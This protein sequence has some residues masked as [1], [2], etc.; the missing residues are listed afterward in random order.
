MGNLDQLKSRAN[1]IRKE[2]EDG[3]N[4]SDRVGGLLEDMVSAMQD[5]DNKAD[6]GYYVCSTSGGTSAKAVSVPGFTLSTRGRLL[7]KMTYSNTAALPSLNINQTG[8]KP[9]YYNGEVA[10]ADNTWSD[11][12][13]LDVYYDGT[14][15]QASNVQ[16]GTDE[17]ALL[18][19]IPKFVANTHYYVGQLVQYRGQ[20]YQNKVEYQGQ[21]IAGNWEKSSLYLAARIPQRTVLQTSNTE[22]DEVVFPDAE[23][24]NRNARW[25]DINGTAWLSTSNGYISTDVVPCAPFSKFM[26]FTL[27]YGS[28]WYLDVNMRILA[29][30]VAIAPSDTSF[31]VYTRQNTGQLPLTKVVLDRLDRGTYS[32]ILNYNRDVI[33]GNLLTLA[34]TMVK[35]DGSLG[36]NSGSIASELIDVAVGDVFLIRNGRT[37]SGIPL[38][39]EC[40]Y[41]YDESGSYI[42]TIKSYYGYMYVHSDSNVKK[43][44]FVGVNRLGTSVKRFNQYAAIDFYNDS[45]TVRDTF[46]QLLSD[47][48]VYHNG[49]IV[50]REIFPIEVTLKTF[51]SGVAPA[52]CRFDLKALVQERRLQMINGTLFPYVYVT[53]QLLSIGDPSVETIKI[54]RFQMKVG[55]V[56]KVG[57]ES[58]AVSNDV[59][60][61]I[62]SQQSGSPT[63][64]TLKI[65]SVTLGG[66]DDMTGVFPG[67]QA[68]DLAR[69]C[70]SLVSPYWY[71]MD[72]TSFGDSITYLGTYNYPRML[73]DEMGMNLNNVAVP[74]TDIFQILND[75][76]LSLLSRN[77][78][79]VTITAGSN[80]LAVEYG[81]IDSRDRT[82][83]YGCINYAIDYILEKCPRALIMLCPAYVTKDEG[84]NVVIRH[85]RQAFYDI[86]NHRGGI[87]VCDWYT[88]SGINTNTVSFYCYDGVHPNGRTCAILAGLIKRKMNFPVLNTDNLVNGDGYNMFQNG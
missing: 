81:D 18:G 86:S 12:E 65:I 26:N 21:W 38:S 61:S 5:L 53:M 71:G 9:L 83:V 57:Y 67:R 55:D 87:P 15:Y 48:G 4:T 74:G 28:I 40:V 32:E 82:T 23:F 10:N 59:I 68:V 88:D 37:T 1:V 76:R 62:Q 30:N 46:F 20:I 77:T 78:A 35:G 70:T 25:V 45:L 42:G 66:W 11:G 27:G 85:I 2:V 43:V 73:A 75:T 14:N 16:G 44:R 17:V 13:V 56:I 63:S 54:N 64:Y 7:I 8:A 3:A 34:N 72:Y 49:D 80:G 60:A 29:K 6:G 79:L 24:A 84:R 36:Y 52:D 39:M 22:Y 33:G 47:N 58:S 69:K 19:G 51:A 31:F 50:G 41:G